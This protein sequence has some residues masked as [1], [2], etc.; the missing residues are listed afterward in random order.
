MEFL[1]VLAKACDSILRLDSKNSARLW[2]CVCLS[3]DLS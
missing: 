3:I 1:V 2:L